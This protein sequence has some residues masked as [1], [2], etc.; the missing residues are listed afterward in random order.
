MKPGDRVFAAGIALLSLLLLWG[1]ASRRPLC[2]A[3]TGDSDLLPPIDSDLETQYGWRI[4]GA[5]TSGFL[6]TDRSLS[7]GAARFYA[8]LI[9]DSGDGKLAAVEDKSTRTVTVRVK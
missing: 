4:V 8:C 7:R 5:E 1:C 2:H 9:V 3:P 6:P